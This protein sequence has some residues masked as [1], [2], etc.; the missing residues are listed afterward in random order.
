MSW[1]RVESTTPQDWFRDSKIQALISLHFSLPF[2][3]FDF[4]LGLWPHGCKMAAMVPSVMSSQHSKKREHARRSKRIF[5]V[6]IPFLTGGRFS[7]KAC[8][9]TCLYISLTR[10]GHIINL[11]L[12]SPNSCKENIKIAVTGL[13]Y[14]CLIPW[15]WAHCLPCKLKALLSAKKKGAWVLSATL[16]LLCELLSVKCWCTPACFL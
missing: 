6:H 3:V 7:S 11:P 10:L 9:K 15:G 13:E 8:A 4:T 1:Q 14:S 12:S 16:I 2:R 5:L